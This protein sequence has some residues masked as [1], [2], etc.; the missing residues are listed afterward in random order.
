MT[1]LKVSF[2]TPVKKLLT[3]RSAALF[4]MRSVQPV[5]EIANTTTRAMAHVRAHNVF[6]VIASYVIMYRTVAINFRIKPSFVRD[7]K[8]SL[9][10][11]PKKYNPL[12]VY[13]IVRKEPEVMNRDVLIRLTE[14][15]I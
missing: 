4:M 5:I 15:I 12:R 7:K 10:L 8:L 14:I 3:L 13:R 11:L 1:A 2:T 9:P 6:M